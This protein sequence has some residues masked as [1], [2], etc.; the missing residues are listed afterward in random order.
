[1]LPEALAELGAAALVLLGLSAFAA[2]VF[3]A[4]FG[5]GAG[6][7]LSFAVT[8]VF[9]VEAVVPVVS[10]AMMLANAGR[11]SAYR[12]QV[13]RRPL[14]I[15]LA[16]AAP[17]AVLGAHVHALLPAQ[18]VA[19]VIGAILVLA[20][21]LGRVARSRQLQLGDAGLALVSLGLGF[22]GS[23][24][25]GAGALAIPVLLAAGL[26]GPALIAT[27]AALAVGTSLVRIGTFAAIGLLPPGRLLAALLIGL[28]TIPGAWFG[29]YIVARAGVRRHTLAIE[30]F[31]I[32]A[33][34]FFLGQAIR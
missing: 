18:A 23:L 25:I 20:V 26:T 12:S 10:A 17:G 15:A 5:L 13:S 2:G 34:L 22:L 14:L 24:G 31:A 29:A 28:A 11:M 21:P 33:G 1:M 8:G 27:D 3:G 16:A 30:G 32:G 6:I 9:G 19:A 7:L 4:V